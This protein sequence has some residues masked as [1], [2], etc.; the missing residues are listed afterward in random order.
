VAAPSRPTH[1]LLMLAK[2]RTP[3]G[4]ARQHDNTADIAET[5]R[6]PSDAKLR[7]YADTSN[8]GSKPNHN[9][10][11]TEA[12]GER[13]GLTSPDLTG[14]KSRSPAR[15]KYGDRVNLAPRKRRRGRCHRPIGPT[16]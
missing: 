7:R 2:A 4:T 5:S 16:A 9:P 10:M 11:N 13:D 15:F 14:A 1:P 8:D 3:P 12:E 6:G